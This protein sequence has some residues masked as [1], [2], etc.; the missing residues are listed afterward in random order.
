M[1]RK[2]KCWIEDSKIHK[3]PHNSFRVTKCGLITGI[4]IDSLSTSELRV[5]GGTTDTELCEECWQN[6]KVWNENNR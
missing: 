2:H 3:V 1:P 5:L 4:L 6:T